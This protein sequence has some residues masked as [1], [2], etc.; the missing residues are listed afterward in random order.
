MSAR[1]PP[2]F[3]ELWVKTTFTGDAEPMFYRLGLVLAVGVGGDLTGTNNIVQAWQ[4]AIRPCVSSSVT[5]NGGYVLW[6]QDGGDL[7]IDST[8]AVQAGTGGATNL[9]P[10]TALL[11][12]KLT[13]LG[14]RRNRGRMFIPGVP[15]TNVTSA[16]AIG[17]ATLPTYQTAIDAARTAVVATAEVTAVAL[18]HDSAPFAPTTITTLEAQALVATQRRRLR[19]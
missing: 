8:I 10:N 18:F 9:P 15:N 6:G 19:P 12:R 5:L 7:R 16:G 2:G 17:G 13:G 3:A 4:T 14:G 1:I 11:V